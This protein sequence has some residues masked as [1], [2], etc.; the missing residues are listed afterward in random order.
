[1]S[2]Y[3]NR[4]KYLYSISLILKKSL[5]IS[6]FF[7]NLNR[8]TLNIP[9]CK[10]IKKLLALSTWSSEIS[11]KNVNDFNQTK[12]ENKKKANK[13]WEFEIFWKCSAKFLEQFSD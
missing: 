4:I 8:K 13:I 5:I 9:T 3:V 2:N 10:C 12:Y 11:C 6:I 1:M 7:Y